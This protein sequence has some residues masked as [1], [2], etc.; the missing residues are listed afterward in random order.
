MIEV[1]D[2]GIGFDSSNVGEKNRQNKSMGLEN[3]CFRI[4]EISGGSM[5]IFSRPGEGT[6]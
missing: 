4:Q 5:E 6:K 1:E 3:I 2:N